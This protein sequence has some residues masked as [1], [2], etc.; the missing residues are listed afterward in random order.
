MN[1]APQTRCVYLALFPDDTCL[2]AT[3]RKEVSVVRKI[4]RGLSSMES[5]CEL[6]IIKY[7]KIE[8]GGFIF[9]AVGDH[10]SPIIYRIY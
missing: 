4:Q 8:H 7:M 10:L 5:C 1:D 3:D 2:Y 6:E 9:F